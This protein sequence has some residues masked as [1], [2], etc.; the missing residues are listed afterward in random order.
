M[1][2]KSKL[3]PGTRV[4]RLTLLELVD[5]KARKWLC[6]CDCG[7][8]KHV[9]ATN[10]TGERTK[11]CGC[12]RSELSSASASTL[13][14]LN[15]LN[16]QP[17]VT[18]GMRQSSEYVSWAHML[19]R[20]L[21]PKSSNYAYYGGRGIEVCD[22]WLKFENFYEDMGP[23]P[24]NTTLDREKNELGYFKEN[25]RWATKRE[26]ANN[27][28]HN[29]LISYNGETLT[30]SQWAERL[31]TNPKTLFTRLYAGWPTEKILTS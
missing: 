29:R 16:G 2:R 8:L 22:R 15:K 14:E 4:C 21:N 19:D 3:N 12:Y 9:S 1:S 13:A 11:S 7:T 25:C 6:R 30:V 27:S 26:Q 28:R 5:A 24:E 10:L 18:H 20:C 31:G 23:R 17:S